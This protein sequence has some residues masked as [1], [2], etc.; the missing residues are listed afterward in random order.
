MQDDSTSA[1]L[2]PTSQSPSPP[3]LKVASSPSDSSASHSSFDQ[4]E[5]FD[6]FN[7]DCD[8]VIPG[9]EDLFGH[10]TH[11]HGESWE[12][13]LSAEKLDGILL[14]AEARLR[15]QEE[16]VKKLNITHQIKPNQSLLKLSTIPTYVDSTKSIVRPKNKMLVS[17]AVRNLADKPKVVND[18]VTT[19]KQIKNKSESRI[20][21]VHVPNV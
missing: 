20:A 17:E 5:L 16:L 1:T 11:E 13:N 7:Q 19:G 21:P 8:V 10:D 14:R 18:P 9:T 2:S 6:L 12:G 15:E 3:F 4:E